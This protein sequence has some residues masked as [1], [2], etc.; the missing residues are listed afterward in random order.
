M[1]M[2]TYVSALHAEDSC[3]PLWTKGRPT[4]QT[5]RLSIPTRRCLD[6][7]QATGKTPENT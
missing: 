5:V 1:Q 7:I 2:S 6:T 4:Q 3:D